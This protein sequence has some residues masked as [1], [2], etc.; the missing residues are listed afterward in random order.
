MTNKLS[1]RSFGKQLS[2]GAL[3]GLAAASVAPL[4]RGQGVSSQSVK[5]MTTVAR[6]M[7][8]SPGMIVAPAI[9]DAIAARIAEQA[10]FRWIDVAGSEVGEVT[11]ITEPNLCLEDMAEALRSIT[12]AVNIPV[13]VDAGAGFGEPAHVVHTV[14]TLEHAGAAGM[15]MEDQIYPKRFHYFLGVEQT[16]PAEAMVEKIQYA[17]EAR[18]DRDF[19]LIARTDTMRTHSFAEGIRRANLYA[20]AGADIIQL[21]PNTLEEARQTPREVRAPLN[22]VN[23]LGGPGRRPVFPAKE[24][25]TMGYKLLFYTGPS[26]ASYKAVRD[27]IRSLKETGTT[28]MD[29]AVYGPIAK[30]I[31]VTIGLPEYIAIENATT[32]KT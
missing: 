8:K 5:R 20:E 6:E 22:Y 32:K 21:F 25:E 29:S 9:Y 14:R 24:L 16:I 30:E 1:R 11:C 10:G 15:H 13:T 2:E 18:R 17:L 19:V 31:Q 7:I 26:L 3:G 27:V 4:A 28:G 23:G 12:A